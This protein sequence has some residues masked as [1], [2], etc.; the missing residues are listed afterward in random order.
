MDALA[1]PLAA[2][3]L[4]LGCW[5]QTAMGFGMAVLAA[6]IIVLLN[7]LWVPVVL[8]VTALAVSLINAWTHRAHLQWRSLAGAMAARIPGTAA[9]A[10]LLVELDTVQ[11]QLVVALCVLLAIW[12]SLRA[13]RFEATP[14]RLA[15]AG[16][17]S[18]VTGTT[19]SIGGP[20]MALLMQHAAANV[21]RANLSFYFAYSCVISL[22]SYGVAGIL[23]REL[24]YTA[25]SFLPF[26]LLGFVL[27]MRSR[28]FVD[29]GRF[30]RLLLLICSLSALFA[31]GGSLYSLLA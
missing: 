30:R 17:A 18:G 15:W 1:W 13:P 27:G 31:L 8:T 23:N 7:P 24:L 3:A 14:G 19:T 29:A 5:V 20:P 2:L 9:G 11:L 21:V 6:P 10:W 22:L 25:L 16:F 28:H 26:A 12:V 4:L